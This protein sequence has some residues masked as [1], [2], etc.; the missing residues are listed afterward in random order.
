[1]AKRCKFADFVELVYNRMN[2]YTISIET[3]RGLCAENDILLPSVIRKYRVGNSRPAMYNLSPDNPFLETTTI[4]KIIKVEAKF[5]TAKETEAKFLNYIPQEDKCFVP[6]GRNYKLL[7]SVFSENI[8]F[9]MYIYGLPGTSKTI[10]IE[11]LCAH[12]KKPFFR[13]QIS[14]ETVDEDII[15]SFKLINGNTVW[16]DGPAMQAYKSGGILLLDEVDLNPNL[17]ILQNILEGKPFYVAQTGELVHPHEGF[18][19]FATGNTNGTDTD[20]QYVGTTVLN[21]AFLDRF[22]IIIKQ[23]IPTESVEKLILKKMVSHFSIEIE[24]EIIESLVT[25]ASMTRKSYLENTIETYISTRRLIYIIKTYKIIKNITSAVE[26][27]MSRYMSE[28]SSALVLLWKTI[29]TK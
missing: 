18:N 29:Y 7:N 14:R 12:Y 22:A 21:A 20:A 2:T 5:P 9:P 24:D 23:D 26:M 27:S 17:M 3:A 25:W 19:V 10:T 8:F 4:E 13:T 1:M 15:G 16:Q 11:Q 6:N 28:E